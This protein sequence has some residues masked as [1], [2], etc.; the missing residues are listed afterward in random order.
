MRIVEAEKYTDPDLEHC[1]K[2][3]NFLGF[4]QLYVLYKFSVWIYIL[5][6]LKTKNVYRA[7]VWR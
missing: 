4:T 7:G 3:R 5:K 1:K 6:M 2:D